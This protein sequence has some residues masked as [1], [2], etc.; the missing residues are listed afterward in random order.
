MTSD[1]ISTSATA[2]RPAT[3]EIEEL[4]K[5]MLESRSPADAEKLARKALS[6]KPDRADLH[7][8][9]ATALHMQGKAK[10]AEKSY[11]SCLMRDKSNLRAMINMGSL[12]IDGG[13]PAAGLKVLEGALHL[14]PR[15][16]E[17]LFHKGRALGR[18]GE[19]GEAL[20]IFSKLAKQQPDNVDVLKYLALCHMDI[21]H[22]TEA[23]KVLSRAAE[24]APG[25]AVISN[26]MKKLAN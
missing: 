15:H 22:K 26:A 5:A 23:A 13:Q 17:A 18:M 8:A 16:P 3:A 20:Q 11:A 24:L 4:T 25:D 14:S 9:L 12:Q 21:G 7:L 19:A 2:H 1:K 6:L 10:E